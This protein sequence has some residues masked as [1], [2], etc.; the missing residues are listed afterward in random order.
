MEYKRIKGI[1]NHEDKAI[2][3]DYLNIKGILQL[4]DDLS[5]KH[6]KLKGSIQGKDY[7]IKIENEANIKG[8]VYLNSLEAEYIKLFGTCSIK[9]INVEELMFLA[10]EKDN[11]IGTIT[12]NKVSVL[13]N[14]D[15]KDG[16]YLSKLCSG[17]FGRNIEFKKSKQGKSFIEKIIAKDVVLEDSIVDFV[18]CNNLIL[19][20]GCTVKNLKV[21]D[22]LQI[23]DGSTVEKQLP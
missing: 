3:Y 5:C 17:I 22:N 23:E 9:D 15:Q 21:L 12:A 16:E 1:Y 2:E 4:S 7:T 19:K 6:L 13:K 10:D 8:E 20:K 18:E 14:Y 11:N